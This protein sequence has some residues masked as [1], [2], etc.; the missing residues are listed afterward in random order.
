M[1]L[2]GF[3]TLDGRIFVLTALKVLKREGISQQGQ[4]TMEP[5]RGAPCE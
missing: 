1:T 3:L 4:A 5:F 2:S